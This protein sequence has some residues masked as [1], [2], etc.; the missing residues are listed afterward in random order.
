MRKSVDKKPVAINS[1]PFGKHEGLALEFKEAANALPKNFF[2]TVCAFLNMD[3]GLILLGVAD[4][5]TVTGVS[6]DVVSR[7]TAEIASLSNNPAKLDPPNLL[8][9]HA[10]SPAFSLFR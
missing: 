2:E 10:E 9:P 4:D 3:G 8:F 6:A 5:G 1:F 7:I